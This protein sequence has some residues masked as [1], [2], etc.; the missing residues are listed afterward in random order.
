L[1]PIFWGKEEAEEEIPSKVEA[2]ISTHDIRERDPRILA[3]WKGTLCWF[4][5]LDN[6]LVP[7]GTTITIIIIIIIII[8]NTTYKTINNR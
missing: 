3:S 1:I 2:T 7:N 8:T 4:N 6:G 5:P